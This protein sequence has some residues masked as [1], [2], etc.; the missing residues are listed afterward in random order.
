MRNTF[1]LSPLLHSMFRLRLAAAD[2]LYGFFRPG[3]LP[4]SGVQCQFLSGCRAVSRQNSAVR[5]NHSLKRRANSAPSGPR[6]ATGVSCT[7]RASRHA[8]GSRLAQTLGRTERKFQAAYCLVSSCPPATAQLGWSSR[9]DSSQLPWSLSNAYRQL[10]ALRIQSAKLRSACKRRFAPCA[11]ARSQSAE[12]PEG[13]NWQ[14][15][16]SSLPRLVCQ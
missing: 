6:G 11:E 3:V 16:R 1:K 4:K 15:H 9:K 7:A 14:G 10:R 5:P 8:V 13:G 2:A 12:P